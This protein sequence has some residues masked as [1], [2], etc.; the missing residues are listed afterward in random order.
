ML[1]PMK[2]KRA[3]EISGLRFSESRDVWMCVCVC[4]CV[5]VCVCVCVRSALMFGQSAAPS[6]CIIELNH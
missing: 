2:R 5:R 1:T 3:S 4:V 6:S